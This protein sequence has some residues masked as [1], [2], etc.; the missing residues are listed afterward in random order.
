M[1]SFKIVL[2]IVGTTKEGITD[3]APFGDVSPRKVDLFVVPQLSFTFAFYTKCLDGFWPQ[4][5]NTFF[6]PSEQLPIKSGDLQ[7][8]TR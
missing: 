4:E 5:Q 1:R 7:A 6:F 3:A 2:P 8:S